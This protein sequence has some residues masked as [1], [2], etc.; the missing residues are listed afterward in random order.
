MQTPATYDDANLMLRLY[1]MRREERLRQAR[2]W[3]TRNFHCATF[4]EFQKKCPPG[5]QENAFARQ[6]IT[7]WEM[8]ASFITT[9][10]LNEHL[11]F[12]SGM[13]LLLVWERVREFIDD[14][15]A[16]QKNPAAWKNLEMV[17]TKYIQH[18]NH[19]DPETYPAFAARV[20]AMRI[21]SEK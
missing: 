4:E 21:L 5:S 20:R 18:L 17:A 2:D 12:Q 13:E 3:F 1:D 19:I 7:Y 10:V 8:V 15:R 16:A 11:F 6:V 9:G 14:M